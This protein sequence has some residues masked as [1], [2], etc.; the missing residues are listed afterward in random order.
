MRSLRFLKFSFSF[1]LHSGRCNA[2]GCDCPW[3]YTGIYCEHY[4]GPGQGST[5]YRLHA[6]PSRIV[7]IF[8]PC[9]IFLKNM[10]YD[11]LRYYN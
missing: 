11:K 3:D 7:V 9:F 5:G 1:P 8:F 4:V 2:T 10:F 6:L